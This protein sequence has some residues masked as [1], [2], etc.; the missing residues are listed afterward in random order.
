MQLWM[1]INAETLP[2]LFK[3]NA[4]AWQGVRTDFFV[5]YSLIA[6]KALRVWKSFYTA[7]SVQHVPVVRFRSPQ[8][9]FNLV[10]DHDYHG[11]KS[12]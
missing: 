3:N 12:K 8:Q 11:K 5:F 4:T 2:K 1:G 7:F 10:T 9:C 6:N